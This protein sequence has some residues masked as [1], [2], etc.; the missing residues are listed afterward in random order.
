MIEFIS[1]TKKYPSGQ[2]ALEDI[3]LK[4]ESGEFIFLVGESGAGKTT[5]TNLICRFFD[6]DGV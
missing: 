1:V 2:V 6:P 3:N 5:I 4:V